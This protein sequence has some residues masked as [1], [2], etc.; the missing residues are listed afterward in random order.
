MFFFYYLKFVISGWD[1]T[2]HTYGLQ[3]KTH[4]PLLPTISELQQTMIPQAYSI[5]S[6]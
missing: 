2:H 3:K 1:V 6:I 4:Q 5:N